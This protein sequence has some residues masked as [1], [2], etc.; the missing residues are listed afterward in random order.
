[1]I[2]VKINDLINVLPLTN[3]LEANEFIMIDQNLVVQGEMT[4][5]EVVNIVKQQSENEYDNETNEPEQIVTDTEAIKGL[6][7][8]FKYVQQKN[9]DIDFQVIRSVNKLKREISYK[10]F[11]YRVQM[12]IEDYMLVE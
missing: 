6:E 9:L 8:A 12:R 5:E 1:M 7:M 3:S 11:Q 10:I 2:I 4:E